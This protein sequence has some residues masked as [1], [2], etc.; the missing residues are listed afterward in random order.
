ME[1][2]EVEHNKIFN[3]VKLRAHTEGAYTLEAWKTIVDDVIDG[4]EEF[5]EIKDVDEQNLKDIL[6]DRFEEFKSEI[7]KA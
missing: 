1:F 4:H 5:G 7:P 6:L 3:E 2:L